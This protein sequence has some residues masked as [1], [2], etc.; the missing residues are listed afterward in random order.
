MGMD[1]FPRAMTAGRD[2]VRKFR[3]ADAALKVTGRGRYHLKF[4]QVEGKMLS[5][6]LRMVAGNYRAFSLAETII[7]I[8]IS[9]IL[10]SLLLPLL[11]KMTARAGEAACMGN[12]RQL[13]AAASL[14]SAENDGFLP[15]ARM[16]DAQGGIVNWYQ[17]ISPYIVKDDLLRL[18]C[19]TWKRSGYFN[20]NSGT[21]AWNFQLGWWNRNTQIWEVAQR[22]VH[23]HPNPS[24]ESMIVD[25]SGKTA[26]DLNNYYQYDYGQPNSGNTCPALHRKGFHAAFID[27]HVEWKSKD[28]ILNLPRTNIFWAPASL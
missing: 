1:I 25:G 22:K 18:S 26:A 21:Y 19:P 10:V 6:W 17:V 2:S 16:A 11:G 7:V 5:A 3:R 20:T 8:G 14:Y 9:A 15:G 27:G 4:M 13:T 12:L 23:A 24:S 28:S